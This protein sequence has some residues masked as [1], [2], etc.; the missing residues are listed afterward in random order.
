[1]PQDIRLPYVLPSQPEASPR[2]GHVSFCFRLHRQH[3]STT[4]D[5][6]QRAKLA[7][8]E[9]TALEVVEPK[10]FA[11]VACHVQGVG[12]SRS[13][14]LGSADRMQN[15]AVAAQANRHGSSSYR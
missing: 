10:A 9:F 8:A 13:Q 3:L 15:L 6:E 12:R 5:N 4:F 2:L 7:S 14:I 1:M 11:D